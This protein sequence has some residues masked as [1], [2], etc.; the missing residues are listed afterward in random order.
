MIQ[1]ILQ[2]QFWAAV[3]IYWVFSAAVSSMPEPELT[4]V[5]DICGCI[6]FCTR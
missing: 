1:F 2:H 3:A 5:R 6:G 4:A